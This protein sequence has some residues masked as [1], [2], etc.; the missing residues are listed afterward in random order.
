M[1]VFSSYAILF[2]LMIDI[3]VDDLIYFEQQAL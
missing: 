3:D 2:N 1:H